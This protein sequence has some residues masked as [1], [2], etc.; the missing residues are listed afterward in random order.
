MTSPGQLG[1]EVG[2]GQWMSVVGGWRCWGG[3][4]DRSEGILGD[5]HRPKGR[6]GMAGPSPCEQG[7]EA[8]REVGKSPFGVQ[9]RAVGTTKMAPD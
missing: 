3:W 4:K 5:K 6:G 1:L 2:V 7:R 8:E 9:E